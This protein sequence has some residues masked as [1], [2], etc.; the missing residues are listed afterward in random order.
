MKKPVLERSMFIA[1]M[2]KPPKSESRG[3]LT[4]LEDFDMESEKEDD[5]EDYEERTPDNLEIIANNLRGD[6]RSM[7][8]RYM[9]LAQMVG[10]S[11]FETPEEV[12]ALMQSQLAQQQ[13]PPMPAPPAPAQQGI[14][15]LPGASAP[16]PG[17]I[18]SGIAEPQPTPQGPPPGVPMPPQ[19]GMP[20]GM[21]APV[22][23]AQG[24]LVYRAN[25]ST[26]GGETARRSLGFMKYLDP[27][28]IPNPRDVPP[29]SVPIPR[30]QLGPLPAG[31]GAYPVLS[32]QA[33]DYLRSGMAGTPTLPQQIPLGLRLSTGAAEAMRNVP[34]F[35]R[36]LGR[37]MM[38]TPAGRLATGIGTAG[39]MAYPFLGGGRGEE[40]GGG[41]E[42]SEVPGV[43]AE[44]RYRPQLRTLENMPGTPEERAAVRDVGFDDLS[45]RL[46]L[47]QEAIE[48]ATP[49]AMMPIEGPPEPTRPVREFPSVK[50]EV[51]EARPRTE[52][53]IFRDRVKEKMDIYSEFLGSDPEMRKA[54]A[55]FLLAE[56]ALNVAGATGRSTAERL[57]K[58]LKGLP[59]GMAALGSE[60][61]R[62][63]RAIAS[64]SITSVEQDMAEERKAAVAIQRELIKKGQ[65]QNLPP[66]VASLYSS[67]LARFPNE[68]P[69]ALLQESFDI[70][71]GTLVLSEKTGEVIDTMTGQVRRTKYE[72]LNKN[73]VGYIDPNMPYTR[74]TNE[75]LVPATP[76]EREK[77]LQRRGELQKR[78]EDN[79][80]MVSLIYGD[81]IGFLPSIQSG[82]SK[83]TLATVGDVGLGLTDVQK[84]AIRDRL[85]F[86]REQLIKTNLRNAGRP[87]VYDQQKMEQLIRDPNALFQSPELL[88]ANVSNLQMEDVNELARIDSQLFGSPLKQV[89]RV[90]TGSKTDP[91]AIGPNTSMLLDQ[92]FT[93]RP[94]AAIWTVRPDGKTVRITGQE[95]FKQRQAQ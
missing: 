95:Y 82:V 62:E 76:S 31:G 16:P 89:D 84:N 28:T 36:E 79:N 14:A 22:G 88:L 75:T 37:T 53:E 40:G 6:I 29:R 11:A 42:Y 56:A 46:G 49:G 21:P 51:A 24:G 2:G 69:R 61:E 90:P 9:E 32:A 73:S 57:S 18:M 19:G 65:G 60:A 68:D 43:D 13:Q 52:R 27:G 54:Q 17:G 70:D 7:D 12:V 72:P 66:K 74:V 93:N 63:R 35:T 25:G 8:E 67:L 94:N 64:A 77:L 48:A 4:G 58:G 34:G 59:A 92:M 38:G 80:Q 81:A 41:P 71:N 5:L 33:V 78:V 50:A 91:I 45:F 55:L 20:E 15:G 83:I 23:M 10:E 85:Q 87:A 1:A 30:V 3:I 44:G 26:P 86:N 39:A 47:P